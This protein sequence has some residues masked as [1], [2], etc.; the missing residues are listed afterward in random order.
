[1]LDV[2]ST[3]RAPVHDTVALSEALSYSCATIRAEHSTVHQ[4]RSDSSAASL[5]QRVPLAADA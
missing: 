5:T 4:A 3:A 1:M 2:S